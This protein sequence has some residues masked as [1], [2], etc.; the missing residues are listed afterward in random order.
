MHKGARVFFFSQLFKYSLQHI[1]A[2]TFV[3]T[4]AFP[5]TAIQLFYYSSTL[6]LP[7]VAALMA[8][9]FGLFQTGDTTGHSVSHQT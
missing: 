7:T 3:C 1:T 6:Q 5:L 8:Y 2:T 4:S 9:T